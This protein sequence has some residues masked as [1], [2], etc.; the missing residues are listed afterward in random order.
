MEKNYNLYS[1][2]GIGRNA[3]EEAIANRIERIKRWRT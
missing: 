2:I 1:L 3:S